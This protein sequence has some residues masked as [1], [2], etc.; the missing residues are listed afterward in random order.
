MISCSVLNGNHPMTAFIV[1][2]TSAKPITFSAGVIKQSQ[3]MGPQEITSSF[4]VQPND[5][6]IAR[7]TYFK[8]DG[9]NPQHWFSKFEM[10]PVEGIEFND[11]R[12]AENWKKSSKDNVPIY[13]FTINK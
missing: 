4:T 1:K 11:P 5:S 3:I 9:E 12:K 7:Q 2:N 6:I 13:T 8:K 10:M